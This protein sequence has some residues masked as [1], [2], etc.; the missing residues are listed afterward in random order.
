MRYITLD[1]KDP[2]IKKEMLDFLLPNECENLFLVGNLNNAFKEACYIGVYD[3]KET[4]V[5]IAGY[6]ALYHSLALWSENKEVICQLVQICHERFEIECLLGIEKVAK[7]AY[8]K[9]MALGYRPINK[10]TNMFMEMDIARDFSP[11]E[12]VLAEGFV[13]FATKE[14]GEALAL[15]RRNFRAEED[16]DTSEVTD[17]EIKRASSN[18][19][20]YVLEVNKKVVGCVVSNGLGEH[21]FQILQ[22]VVHSDYRNRGFC[23]VLCSRMIRDMQKEGAHKA[24]LFTAPGNVA[25]KKCYFSLGFK[26]TDIFYVAFLKKLDKFAN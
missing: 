7:I 2:K 21:A 17:K 22:V 19:I 24:V 1:H 18:A 12:K 3:D 8:K 16:H 13:R 6:F 15:L 11:Y 4:L 9:L 5:G 20:I 25:A 23:K 10:P 26:A 14:D